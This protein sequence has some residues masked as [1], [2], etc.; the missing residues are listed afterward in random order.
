M[1]NW[2]EERLYPAQPFREEKAK[3]V[4]L[5]L[6]RLGQKIKA[7]LLLTEL[8]FKEH[9]QDYKEEASGIPKRESSSMTEL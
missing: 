8:A 5:F 7:L 2:Y 1:G 3:A 4:L 9:Y 6:F